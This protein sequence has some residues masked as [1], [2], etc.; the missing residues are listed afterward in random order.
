[1]SAMP[2]QTVVR[3]TSENSENRCTFPLTMARTMAWKLLQIMIDSLIILISSLLDHHSTLVKL[4]I[5]QT[6]IEFR[7]RDL[8]TILL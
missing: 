7:H 4:Y 5:G 6:N 8:L 3:L 1:M 2:R